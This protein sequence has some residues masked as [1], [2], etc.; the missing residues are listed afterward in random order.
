VLFT[1]VHLFDNY[2]NKG[3]NIFYPGT[4]SPLDNTTEEDRSVYP[5]GILNVA[6]SPGT[7]TSDRW[8]QEFVTKIYPRLLEF[9]PDFILVSAGFDAHERDQIHEKGDTGVTEL[10]YKWVTESL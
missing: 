10:D 5:G 6:L 7:A 8:R 9:K 4:G 3:G 1:S 2:E